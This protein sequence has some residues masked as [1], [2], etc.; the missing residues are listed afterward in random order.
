[1]AGITTAA[2]GFGSSTAASRAMRM[3]RWK[4]AASRRALDAERV[5]KFKSAH[6]VHREH[7]VVPLLLHCL[8]INQKKTQVFL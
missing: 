4:A 1:M 2:P 5:T 8:Y 6:I 7:H 3:Q